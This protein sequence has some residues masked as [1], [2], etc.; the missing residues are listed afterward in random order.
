MRVSWRKMTQAAALAMLCVGFSL[1]LRATD[2][3]V[4]DLFVAV[5]H[6]T[7]LHYTN[8]GTDSSP[9]YVLVETIAVF[10]SSGERGS[11]GELARRASGGG[12]LAGAGLGSRIEPPP[13]EVRRVRPRR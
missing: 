9:N 7:Y 10:P 5:G 12:P 4:G 13:R 3:K 6:G 11:G 8:S 1:P 2:W